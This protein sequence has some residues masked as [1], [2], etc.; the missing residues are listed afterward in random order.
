MSAGPGHNS[1]DE[2]RK[3]FERACQLYRERQQND[4]DLAEL[5]D[6]AKAFGVRDFADIRA[7]ARAHVAPPEK[8]AKKDAREQRLDALR[9]EFGV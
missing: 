2:R 4:A 7:V 1:G 5:S 8:Q 6:E 3:M 9:D